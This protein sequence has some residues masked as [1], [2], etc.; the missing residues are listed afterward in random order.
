MRKEQLTFIPQA[1][2]PMLRTINTEFHSCNRQTRYIIQNS[3]EEHFTWGVWKVC[4]FISATS[5][6]YPW[7]LIAGFCRDLLTVV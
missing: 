7:V 1:F 3:N 5:F 4:L 6:L 2:H